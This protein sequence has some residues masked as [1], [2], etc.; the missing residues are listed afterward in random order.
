[1]RNVF[2]LIVRRGGAWQ[3]AT[4]SRCSALTRSAARPS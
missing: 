3:K 2:V 1:M 4:S